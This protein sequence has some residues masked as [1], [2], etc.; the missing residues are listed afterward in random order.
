MRPHH[1]GTVTGRLMRA[2]GTEIMASSMTEKEAGPPGTG[3][4]IGTTAEQTTE[5]SAALTHPPLAGVN[6][7][8][9]QTVQHR[10][11][12]GVAKSHALRRAALCGGP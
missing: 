5:T 9:I 1:T 11:S 10:F 3:I 2:A 12:P 6:L 7:Y 4:G 8:I